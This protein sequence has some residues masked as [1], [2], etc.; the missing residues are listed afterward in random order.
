MT[1]HIPTP[2]KTFNAAITA[3]GTK[4]VELDSLIKGDV[5]LWCAA[6]FIKTNDLEYRDMDKWEILNN[7]DIYPHHADGREC[8]H[9]NCACKFSPKVTVPNQ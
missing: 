9:S 8:K 6:A 7:D 5:F 3:N 2:L 1:Y 4:K